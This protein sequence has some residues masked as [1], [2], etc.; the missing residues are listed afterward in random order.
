MLFRKGT[1]HTGEGEVTTIISSTRIC[2]EEG[3][4]LLCNLV[5]SLPSKL[6]ASLLLGNGMVSLHIGQSGTEVLVNVGFQDR[7]KMLE[8]DVSYQ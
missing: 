3:N 1:W 6:G 7:I 2:P 8:L 5:S 4:S